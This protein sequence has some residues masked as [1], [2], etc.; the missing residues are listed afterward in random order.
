MTGRRREGGAVYD[1]LLRQLPLTQ[2][3]KLKAS[4]N[5]D[6][7]PHLKPSSSMSTLSNTSSETRPLSSHEEE[8]SSSNSPDPSPDTL[9][10]HL[11]N[12]KRSLTS[13]NHVWRANEICNSTRQALENSAVTTARSS[14]LR[15]GI[16]SQLNLLDGVQQTSKNTADLGKAEFEAVVRDLDDAN[17]RLKA[18]LQNLRETI[19]EAKLRPEE[20]EKRNLLSFVDEKSVEEALSGTKRVIQN[21]GEE[22]SRFN[23]GCKGFEEGIENIKT[24]LEQ[25]RDKNGE[26]NEARSP[27][28]EIMHEMDDHAREM[29]VNLESLV[30]HFDL[31]VT[32]IKH[33]EGGGDAASKI[34]NDL[35]D[36]VDIGKQDA[37]PLSEEEKTHMMAVLQEDAGQVD[38]VVSEIRHHIAAMELLNE[39]VED[40]T[41][42]SEKEHT[43]TLTAF[44]SLEVMGRNLPAYLT[45]S[46]TFLLRW[47]DEKAKINEKLEEL[48][49]LREFYDG[50]L[51]AYDSLLIEIGR[52]K[53]M[54]VRMER[55]V[56]EAAA[57][58]EKMYEDDVEEREAFRKEQGDFL[59]VDIWPGL[60][61]APLRYHVLADESSVEKVPD[62]SKSVIHRAIRRVHGEH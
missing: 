33:V 45:Q 43:N 5:E 22:I 32:A 42:L 2:R 40:H 46:K 6:D 56:Q 23:Q 54:E 34:T 8:K 11:L 17:E 44:A 37:Q 28:P 55:L 21:A 50:F 30:S 51:R 31:C 18:T 7:N 27:L 38:E 20:E 13:I 36:G 1:I 62:I 9:L 49:G 53:A 35:P 47:E 58:V 57:R 26:W 15:S 41:S 12:S 52:R 39:R 59:P 60:M 3:E 25:E 14:F 16:R 19:V 10:Q 24:L 61:N 4:K 29:A 48:E